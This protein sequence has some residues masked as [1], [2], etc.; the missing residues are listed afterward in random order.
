MKN[1]GLVLSGGGARGA[2]EAGV[3]KGM[4]SST[5]MDK[6]TY[7]MG[8]NTV[9]VEGNPIVTHLKPTAHNGSNA[10]APVGSQ[11]VPSQATVIIKG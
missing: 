4:I 11:T 1:V 8:V 3:L 6:V 7:R 2:Y 5:N 10:N 9:K